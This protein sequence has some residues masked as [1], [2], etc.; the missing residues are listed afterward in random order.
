MI[1][2]EVASISLVFANV[3]SLLEIS[4]TILDCRVRQVV[5][6]KL[7]PVAIPDHFDELVLLLTC[8]SAIAE[9]SRVF[10]L[11]D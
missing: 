11:T 1:I 7:V 4:F 2:Q 10:V 9:D 8:Q 3:E 5:N 6:E